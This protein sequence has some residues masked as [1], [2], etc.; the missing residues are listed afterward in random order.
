M[1]GDRGEAMDW[2]ILVAIFAAG[3]ISIMIISMIVGSVR[4][5]RGGLDWDHTTDRAFHPWD[6]D[7]H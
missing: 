6:D 2:K 1:A 5:T 4:S 7:D 3:A